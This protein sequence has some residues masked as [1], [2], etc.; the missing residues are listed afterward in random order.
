MA[1]FRESDGKL[2][3]M[4]ETWKMANISKNMAKNV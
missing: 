4:A 1:K 2:Q 3:K